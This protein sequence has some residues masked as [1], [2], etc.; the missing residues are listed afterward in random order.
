[1]TDKDGYCGFLCSDI[2]E[3]QEKIIKDIDDFEA[4]NPE[5]AQTMRF[6]ILKICS[7]EAFSHM[8]EGATIAIPQ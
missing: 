5:F 7:N 2:I 4:Y 6:R 8:P 3:R 1:M